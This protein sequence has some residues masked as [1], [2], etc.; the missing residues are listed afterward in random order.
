[1]N[2]IYNQY[3]SALTEVEERFSREHPK[4]QMVKY[5]HSNGAWRIKN[6][7]TWCGNSV[8]GDL[9]M[10]GIDLSTL[11]VRSNELREKRKAERTDAIENTRYAYLSIQEKQQKTEQ[12][13]WWSNYTKYLQTMHWY[14]LRKQVLERDKYLCQACLKGKATQV[15]HLSYTLFNSIGKSMAFELIAICYPCHKTIHPHMATEQLRLSDMQ[16]T[17]YINNGWKP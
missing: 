17:P 15:H 3:Y 12:E 2:Q 10:T 8:G 14:D 9:K 11:P 6:Q 7:C 5:Q 1:M 16:F 13:L 4:L